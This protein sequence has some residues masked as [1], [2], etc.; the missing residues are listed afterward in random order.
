M[1]SKTFSRVVELGGIRWEFRPTEWPDVNGVYGYL[2][3]P[4]PASVQTAKLRRRALAD[5][6]ED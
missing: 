3:P 1:S 2:S 6:K 4:G 5:R